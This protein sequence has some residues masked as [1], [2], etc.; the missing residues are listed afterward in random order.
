[1]SI[2][3]GVGIGIADQILGYFGISPTAIGAKILGG[4]G[5]KKRRLLQ[6]EMLGNA[7]A[8]HVANMLKAIEGDP[9]EMQSKVKDGLL[10][11]LSQT[12]AEIVKAADF[13][14]STG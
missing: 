14:G 11:T 9:P 2:T 6:I 10:L 13:D 12:L 8:M 7:T 3:V 5:D 4:G 1:M